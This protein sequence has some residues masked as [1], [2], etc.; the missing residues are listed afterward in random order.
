[1]RG[2]ASAVI[3]AISDA[4]VRQFFEQKFIPSEWY[5]AMPGVV[6]E[7]TAA[8]LRGVSFEQHRRQIG[9]WH[10]AESIRGIYAALFKVVSEQSVGMW[11][12]RISSL[13][14]EFGKV[15]TK[16]AGSKTIEGWWRGLP[17]QLAQSVCYASAGF[18]AE[19]LRRTGAQE[20]FVT[21]HEVEPDGAARGVDVVRVRLRMGWK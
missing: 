18:G 15:E 21:L 11:A 1:M 10:A 2:G 13:Y 16:S 9:A 4:R 14:F 6:I 8:R 17:P 5:D 19:A 3:G 12:P 7:S 20:P